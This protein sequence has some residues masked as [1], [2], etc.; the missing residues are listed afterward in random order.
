LLSRKSKHR[1]EPVTLAQLANDSTLAGLTSVFDI[2]IAPSLLDRFPSRPT[3]SVVA[4]KETLNGAT[5]D[6]L[7]STES[8]MHLD[9][10]LGSEGNLPPGPNLPPTDILHSDPNLSSGDTLRPDSN[11]PSGGKLPKRP[12]FP[13]GLDVSPGDTLNLNNDLPGKPTHPPTCPLG[14]TSPLMTTWVRIRAYLSQ[15][16]SSRFSVR[17]RRSHQAK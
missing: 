10:K 3:E 2:P 13:S 7:S 1:L 8:K 11:L 9:D 5:L 17:T 14:P 12:I 15:K 4:E 6:K 16:T